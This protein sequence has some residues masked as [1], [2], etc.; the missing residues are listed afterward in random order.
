MTRRGRRVKG[1]K[2]PRR[3][4]LVYASSMGGRNGCDTSEE[5]ANEHDVCYPLRARTMN[6][7]TYLAQSRVKAEACGAASASG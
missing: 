1:R 6:L 5:A 4:P 3:K 2:L 7:V